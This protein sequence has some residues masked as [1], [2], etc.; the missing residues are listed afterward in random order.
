MFS[1]RG[2]DGSDGAKGRGPVR[3]PKGPGDFLFEFRHSNVAF[4][5]IVVERNPRVSEK[6]KDIFGVAAQ[7]VPEVE[8]G[9]KINSR[10]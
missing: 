7:A 10:R 3:G 9:Q 1:Q 8:R 4:G 5:L 6:T 2:E